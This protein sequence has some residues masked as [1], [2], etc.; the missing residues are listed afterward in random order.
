[1][2]TIQS[3]IF[4]VWHKLYRIVY[5]DP[6]CVQKVFRLKFERTLSRYYS[7]MVVEYR[8]DEDHKLIETERHT[9]PLSR[10]HAANSS[11]HVNSVLDN[12]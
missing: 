11:R 9:T 6:Q 12:W 5:L 3:Q 8:Q 1:M 2:R 7:Q 10:P 4:K